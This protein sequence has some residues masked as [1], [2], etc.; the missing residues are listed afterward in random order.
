MRQR[1]E[2]GVTA[3]IGRPRSSKAREKLTYLIC[4][5]EK[6][7]VKYFPVLPNLRGAS[8]GRVQKISASAGR[9]K[10]SPESEDVEPPQVLMQPRRA[11]SRVQIP[12]I[13]NI[14]ECVNVLEEYKEVIEIGFV[15]RRRRILNSLRNNLKIR[16]RLFKR[17]KTKLH[18]NRTMNET[19][20][21]LR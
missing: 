12:Y 1:N 11:V 2:I 18:R 15:K 7:L 14:P 3:K 10:S 21:I 20:K 6:H 9:R 5:D 8:R 17:P 16:V 19:A 4:N 13:P